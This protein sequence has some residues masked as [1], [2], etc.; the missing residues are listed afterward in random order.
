MGISPCGITLTH[1]ELVVAT[2]EGNIDE[3]TLTI[4]WHILEFAGILVGE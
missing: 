3:E 4:D 1:E 2:A